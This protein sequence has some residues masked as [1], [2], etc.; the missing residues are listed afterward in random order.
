MRWKRELLVRGSNYRQRINWNSTFSA[1]F[2]CLRRCVKSFFFTTK[3]KILA[4]KRKCPVECSEELTVTCPFGLDLDSNGCAKT[5]QCR[6]R[7]PCDQVDC[8]QNEICLLRSRDCLEEICL[9]VPGCEPNPCAENERPALEARGFSQFACFHNLTRP[10]PSQYVCTGYD[11]RQIGVC[12]PPRRPFI[13]FHESDTPSSSQ[14]QCP[15]G[16]PFSRSSDEP[17]TVCSTV[18]QNTCPSTH[19]CVTRPGE[20]HGNCCPTKSELSPYW[21]KFLFFRIRLQSRNGHSFMRTADNSLLLRRWCASLSPFR[22]W[23]MRWKFEQLRDRNGMV[24]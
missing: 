10:C 2:W 3:I 9:P 15:H 4:E 12:C 1:N 5:S 16:G 22:L 14:V 18:G 20:T 7:N 19:Y 11:H 8:P 6:C 24:S 13:H 21:I 23:R 17:A